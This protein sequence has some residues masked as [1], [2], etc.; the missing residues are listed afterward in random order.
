V[1]KRLHGCFLSEFPGTQAGLERLLRDDQPDQDGAV[2]QLATVIAQ[3]TSAGLSPSPT[4]PF[5]TAQQSTAQ[6]DAAQPL[7]P[8]AEPHALAERESQKLALDAQSLGG[9]S[10]QNS[11]SGLAVQA[12]EKAPAA[13][14]GPSKPASSSS[15]FVQ[16]GRIG[17]MDMQLLQRG[18]DV[19]GLEPRHRLMAPANLSAAASEFRPSESSFLTS[20]TSQTSL[21]SAESIVAASSMRA[22]SLRSEPSAS[23]FQRADSAAPHHASPPKPPQLSTDFAQKPRTIPGMPLHAPHAYLI[24]TRECCR[25]AETSDVYITMLALPAWLC[26]QARCFRTK[27]C[28]C[29]CALQGAEH[30][31]P[32]RQSIRKRLME[33]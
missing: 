7:D 24:T 21:S 26:S 15:T 4:V 27:P 5:S 25:M 18:A 8:S 23:G 3:R 14:P 19:L 33:T 12:E 11:L 20:A 2:A 9:R 16:A 13:A 17:W 22:S 31:M 28:T 6:Q 1:R 32:L 29:A 10:S 30:V